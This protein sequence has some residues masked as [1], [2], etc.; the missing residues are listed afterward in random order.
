MGPEVRSVL[1]CDDNIDHLMLIK[2]EVERHSSGFRVTT[3]STARM[4]VEELRKSR[5]DVVLIDYLLRD[6]N[7]L[8]LLREITDGF[9][10]TPTIM[11]TGMGNEDVAVQAMKCGAADYVIKS[12]GSF[13]VVPLVV[14]RVLE[15][16]ALLES[17]HFLESQAGRSSQLVVLGTIALGVAHDLN[18]LL[19][20]VLGRAQL[21]RDRASAEQASQLDVIVSAARDAAAIVRRMLSFASD[22]DIGA[23]EPV[24]LA[25]AVND[26]LEFTRGRWE[27]DARRRGVAYRL[28]VAIP[29]DLVVS[30]P[31][32]ALREIITNLIVNALQAMPEGGSLIIGGSAD[33]GAARLEIRDTGVGMSPATLSRLFTL[34][35]PTAKAGG[36]GVGL[37]TC[38]LLLGRMGGRIEA[39]SEPDVG[40]TFTVSLPL[41]RPGEPEGAK[42]GAPS[43]TGLKVLV[44]DDEPRVAALFEDVLRLDG[45]QVSLACSGEEAM[46]KFEPGRVDVVFCDVGLPGMGGLEIARAMRAL[47][48][49]VALVLV[50]GW[51]GDALEGTIAQ[52]VVDVVATKPL[53]VERIRSLLAEGAALAR[54]RRGGAVPS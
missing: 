3:V 44:V 5:Y 2:R 6:M 19:A 36:H 12:S 28:E 41:R 51:G 21:L 46:S 11:I 47:D 22:P 30:A 34:D 9:P 38:R 42:A 24:R 1:V 32:S 45:Q 23:T 33:G 7:G 50:T 52:R 10:A 27:A 39:Q 4:C 48:P 25:A 26:S 54:D 13:A 53:D 20:A 14:E 8:D 37:A 29:D 49:A 18:E 15:R 43:P 35:A 40:S 16:Q 17:K 31:P